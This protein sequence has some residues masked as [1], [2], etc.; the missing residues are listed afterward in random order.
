MGYGFAAIGRQIEQM[1]QPEPGLQGLGLQVPGLRIGLGMSM[2]S[3]LQ[4]NR[5][6]VAKLQEGRNV[7]D[8]KNPECFGWGQRG[9]NFSPVTEH[10]LLYSQ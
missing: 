7:V 3:Q 5:R 6:N 1:G 9:K 8:Q 2:G 4:R 10:H